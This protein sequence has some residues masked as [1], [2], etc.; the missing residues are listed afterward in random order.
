MC[1]ADIF[2]HMRRIA[3]GTLSLAALLCL[4]AKPKPVKVHEK[5]PDRP[6]S[7]GRVRVETRSWGSSWDWNQDTGVLPPSVIGAIQR[8]LYRVGASGGLEK[9]LAQSET[10]SADALLWTF[11]I[12][13]DVKWS[14]GTPLKAQHFVDG[15]LRACA[16]EVPK[17]PK[18]LRNIEGATA[19][20]SR[21]S[22]T[23]P[24]VRAT[25]E[26]T[27]EVRLL[28]PDPLF[29]VKWLET[30]LLPARGDLAEAHAKSYGFEPEKMAFLGR[31]KL[32]DSRPG[33][34]T[35]MVPNP[36]H[37]QPSTVTRIELWHTPDP[38]QARNLFDRGHLDLSLDPMPGARSGKP[39]ILETQNLVA[40]VPA[41][42]RAR[43]PAASL[44]I[45]TAIDRRSLPTLAG[46]VD[47]TPPLLW[48]LQ[49]IGEPPIS[50][51][52]DTVPLTGNA[53][54]ARERLKQAGGFSKARP[55]IIASALPS[56]WDEALVAA[57]QRQLIKSLGIPVR[58]VNLKGLA[59]TKPDWILRTWNRSAWSIEI[60]LEEIT[61]D[62]SWREWN[63]IPLSDPRRTSLYVEKTRA[64]LME[65]A[66]LIPLGF[67]LAEL[68]V[69]SYVITPGVAPDGRV[70]L[71]GLSYDPAAL[72]RP[73]RSPPP[74]KKP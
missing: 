19:Y 68:R 53:E 27:F 6:P 4:A 3:I 70:E 40:L 43:N 47:W 10:A 35:L 45:S 52:V 13:P 24:S 64:A 72:I 16:P 44:A 55:I 15:V 21:Q 31:M 63:E 65:R 20:H 14:D 71:A 58:M 49:Q 34:R 50:A 59:G 56:S 37:D 74:K 33:L 11:R 39:L 46:S 29:P 38:K 42:D 48:Q 30:H 28:R 60:Q 22:P 2:L 51:G 1:N 69:K 5:M 41:S 36:V 9:D 61:H 73:R 66:Q 17:L 67:E 54:L 26:R 12:R 32:Q 8:G 25:S 18:S 57:I 7:G 62:P 23:P